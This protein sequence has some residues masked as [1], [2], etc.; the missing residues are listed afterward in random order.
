MTNIALRLIA[1]SKQHPPLERAGVIEE[2]L[3][4]PDQPDQVIATLWAKEAEDRLDAYDRGELK[5][6]A[7]DEVFARLNNK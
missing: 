3:T 4:S 7:A 2:L 6:I 5:A 1:E